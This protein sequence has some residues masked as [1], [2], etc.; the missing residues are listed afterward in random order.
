M[1]ETNASRLRRWLP[2]TAL[3]S[4]FIRGES[5][6]FSEFQAPQFIDEVT[7]N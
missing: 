2:N 5:K 3:L 1:G 4:G 6:I 7:D